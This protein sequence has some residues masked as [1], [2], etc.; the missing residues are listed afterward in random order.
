MANPSAPPNSRAVFATAEASPA[1]C[2]FDARGRADRRGDEGERHAERREQAGHEHLTEVV[3]VDAD[4]CE[5]READREQAMPRISS[6]LAP[7][8]I[9]IRDAI[10]E[11]ITI[12]TVIGRN[13]MPAFSGE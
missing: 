3:A 4:P 5:E 9:V 11:P 13:T 1:S 2:G 10:V 12:A 8:R 7:T 6:R